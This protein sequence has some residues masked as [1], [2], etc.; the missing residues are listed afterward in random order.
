METKKSVVTAIAENVKQWAGQ[1][2]TVHYHTITFANGDTGWYGSK[3]PKCEKFIIG[4]ECDYTKETKVNGQYTNVVIKPLQDQN[5]SRK[6]EPKDQGV[7]TYLSCA[8]TAAQYY[9]QRQSTKEDLYA[10]AEELFIKA[11][12]KSTL[13]K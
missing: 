10:M 5:G 1:N 12:S 13:N 4:K 8:S 11:M 9:H 7:I 3:S 6:F 2:G